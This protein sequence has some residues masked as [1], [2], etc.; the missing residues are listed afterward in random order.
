MQAGDVCIMTLEA[1][2]FN[3]T[4]TPLHLK[5]TRVPNGVSVDHQSPYYLEK[6]Q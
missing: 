3:N 1:N 4:G 2:D 5:F 6:K